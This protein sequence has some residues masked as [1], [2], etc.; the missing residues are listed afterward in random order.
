MSA[1]VSNTCAI[2]LTSGRERKS[3]K[4]GKE[5]KPDDALENKNNREKIVKEGCGLIEVSILKDEIRVFGHAGYAPSG[6]D[7]VCAGV[8]ALSQTLAASLDN[9]VEDNPEYTLDSGVFI[10][11][12]KDLSEKAKLLVDSFFIGVCGIADTYPDYVRIT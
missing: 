7:I 4:I 6:Q 3:K 5:N 12:T 9:L 11:K 10:L 1:H 2:M 8:A